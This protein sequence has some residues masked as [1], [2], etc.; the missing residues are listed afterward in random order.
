MTQAIH[1]SYLGL[2]AGEGTRPLTITKAGNEQSPTH[3]KAPPL[4]QAI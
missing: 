4:L 1:Q 3:A 2:S